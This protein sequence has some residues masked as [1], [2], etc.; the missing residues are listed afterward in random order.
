[1]ALVMITQTF[2]LVLKRTVSLRRLSCVPSS[3]VL[4]GRATVYSY[5]DD[6]YSL[7]W[8]KLCLL[9]HLSRYT[10]EP[11]HRDDFLVYLQHVYCLF[12]QSTS[13]SADTDS[14][15]A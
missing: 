7:S 13:L 2:D 1:M 10:G 14:T 5:L 15:V 4:P 8:P 11:A 9:K 6:E 3:C 12:E